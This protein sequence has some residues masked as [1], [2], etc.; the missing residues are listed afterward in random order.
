MQRANVKTFLVYSESLEVW[1]LGEFPLI[2]R[3]DAVTVEVQADDSGLLGC[4]TISA[5]KQLTKF[6]SAFMFRILI[7]SSP[8]VRDSAL[9]LWK[10]FKNTPA[11]LIGIAHAASNNKDVTSYRTVLCDHCFLTLLKGIRHYICSF[12]QYQ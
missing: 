12:S 7:F 2:Y 1:K 3:V 8:T 6:L 5:R 10:E 11:L 9:H 4:C